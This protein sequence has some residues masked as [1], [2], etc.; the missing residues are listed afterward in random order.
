MDVEYIET[1]EYIE[2]L[3]YLNLSLQSILAIILYG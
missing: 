3:E 2:I 1:L